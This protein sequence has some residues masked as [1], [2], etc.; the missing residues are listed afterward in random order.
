[1]VGFQDLKSLVVGVLMVIGV[2]LAGPLTTHASPA[3]PFAR[4]PSKSVS[5]AKPLVKAK[6]PTAATALTAPNIRQMAWDLTTTTAQD[7]GDWE[8]EILR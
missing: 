3:D 8:Q 7:F 1:M 5:V 4:P 2:M 6:S